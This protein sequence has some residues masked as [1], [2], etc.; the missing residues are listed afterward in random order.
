MPKL[1]DDEI[2]RTRVLDELDWDAMVDAAQIDAAAQRGVVTLVGTVA[3]YG[4]KLAAE[5]AAQAVHGVHDLIND[6]D[7]RPGGDLYP[8]DEELEEMA[9]SVLKWDA[10]VPDASVE[11]LVSSGWITLRGEVTLPAQ[12]DRAEQV[13]GH[14]A[15]VSGVTNQITIETP[16]LLPADVRA[17]IENALTRRAIHQAAHIDIVVDGPTV[18]LAGT[19]QSPL[20]KRAILGAVRHAPGI[21]LVCDELHIEERPVIDEP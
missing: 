3:S 21:N 7:V 13:V 11:A 5:A 20:E 8:S 9:T 1:D 10:L 17:S 16:D 2:L 12:R 19:V 6:I 14:L 15:G 4:E 18:T